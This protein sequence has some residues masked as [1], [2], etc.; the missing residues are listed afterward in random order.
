VL[1]LSGH[2]T[3]CGIIVEVDQGLAAG[4]D[5]IIFQFFNENW[6]HGFMSRSG[7]MLSVVDSR[8]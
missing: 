6:H 7:D 3:R 8:S 2:R 1:G 4:I 5:N